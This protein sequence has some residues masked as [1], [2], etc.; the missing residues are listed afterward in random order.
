M[1]SIILVAAFIGGGFRKIDPLL[2]TK[3]GFSIHSMALVLFYYLVIGFIMI[4]S[5]VTGR[6]GFCHTFCWMAPF[7]VIGRKISVR[8]N[9]KRFSLKSEKELC[10]NC[11]KCTKSCP[12]SLPV[13][14]MVQKE[15]LENSE[16]ILCGVCVD[17][18]PNNAI[19]FYR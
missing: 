16:C 10:S 8:F 4:T 3:N 11:H 7:M 14:N 5:L 6:R 1:L 19:R 13:N 17:E 9:L 15:N 18:C 2:G 12:M